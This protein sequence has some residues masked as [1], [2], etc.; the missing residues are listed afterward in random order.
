MKFFPLPCYLVPVK[1]K[2]S[3]ERTIL[4]QAHTCRLLLQFVMWLYGIPF[5]IKLYVYA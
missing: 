1:P 2:C 5:M 4:K 3:P